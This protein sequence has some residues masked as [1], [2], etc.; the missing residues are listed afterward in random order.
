LKAIGKNLFV[1]TFASG[2]PIIGIPGEEGFG[3]ILQGFL[4]V[5]NV[6]AIQEMVAMLL[7]QR[8]YEMN[9]RAVTATDNMMATT[10]NIVR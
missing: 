10:V 8:V 6:N 2:D 5:S 1:Q 7:A 9:S 4:E 3:R